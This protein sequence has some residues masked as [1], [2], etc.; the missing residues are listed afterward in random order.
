MY[1][2]QHVGNDYFIKN[3]KNEIEYETTDY[4]DAKRALAELEGSVFNGFNVI[5]EYQKLPYEE[6]VEEQKKRSCGYAV[7]ALNVDG[8]INIST[9]IRSA[10]IFGAER[11]IIIGDKKYDRRGTVG[12]HKYIPIDFIPYDIENG[13]PADLIT[14]IKVKGYQNLVAIEQGG[15]KMDNGPNMFS[16]I[17]KPCLILGSESTGIPENV[18]NCIFHRMEIPQAGVMRSLNVSVAGSIAMYNCMLGKQGT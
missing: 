4:K 15:Y 18:L 1:S 3:E 17:G 10:V 16:F 13:D 8:G 14:E 12:A 11:F 5:D 2:I 9:L 7:A 6:I